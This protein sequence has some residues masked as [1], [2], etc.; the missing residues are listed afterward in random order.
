MLNAFSNNLITKPS[1]GFCFA[2]FA[3]LSSHTFVKGSYFP[4]LLNIFCCLLYLQAAE[5]QVEH[6]QLLATNHRLHHKLM[7]LKIA[8]LLGNLFLLIASNA[9]R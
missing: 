1:F 3:D 4:P 2:Q 6:D 7:W 8:K 9:I 5:Q